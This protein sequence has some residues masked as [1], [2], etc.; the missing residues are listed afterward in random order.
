MIVSQELDSGVR[1]ASGAKAPPG[2]SSRL[3]QFLQ[4]RVLRG[5]TL[6]WASLILVPVAVV[7]RLLEMDDVS[8]FLLSVLALIPLAWII[9]EATEQVGEYTGPAIAGLLNATFGNAPE[10]IISLFAVSSGLYEV[11]RAS[12]VGSVIG[13]LLLVLGCSLVA[14]GRGRI[15]RRSAYSAV[16]MV[17]LAI[18]LFGVSSGVTGPIDPS[19]S[20]TNGIAIAVA[21]VLFATYCAVTVRSVLQERRRHREEGTEGDPEWSL[22]RAVVTLGL[23]TVAT[24]A[25][26][27]VLTSSIEEFGAAAGLSDMFVA[28]V[29]VAIAG[30]AAEHGGAVVIAARGNVLLA[31][32]I[33]LQSAAQVATGLI[34]AVVLLSLVISPLPLVFTPVEFIGMAVATLLPALL[35]MGGRT[36]RGHGIALCTAYAGVVAAFFFAV[37]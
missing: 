12:L 9:G 25:V 35:F 28:A 5:R 21:V 16:G 32:E 6:L 20:G 37:G 14:G 30:N 2:S 31:A 17:A 8:L 19:A 13:N 27:E 34:P 3:S 23:A 36:T 22:P 7:A 24:V 10:L 1:T 11:V 4:Q 18:V 26:S 15:G 33:G 29:I